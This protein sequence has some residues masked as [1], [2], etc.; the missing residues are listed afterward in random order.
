M[1]LPM[2]PGL[3]GINYILEETDGLP[4]TVYVMAPS[5]VPATH[6]ETSGAVLNPESV[7][8]LLK[9]PRV[10]GL[11]EM[12]NYPGVL[13]GDETILEKLFHARDR[14]LPID[15]H[16]P[17]LTGKDLQAYISAGIESDHECTTAEEA[18]EKLRSG[19]HLFI[20]EGSVARNLEELLPV[21]TEKNVASLSSRYR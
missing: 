7:A 10:I 18:L 21:V 5:C 15:G 8:E 12:M 9:H 13:A 17:G 1:K 2:S 16:S 20:R 14:T 3:A 4:V 6:L 11:A 19:M